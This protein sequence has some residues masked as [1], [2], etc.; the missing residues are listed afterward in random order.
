MPMN[1]GDYE[2]L[3]AAVAESAADDTARRILAFDIANALVGTSE[4]FDPVL[5]LR[6]C[7]IG[8]IDPQEVAQWSTLLSHRVQ[9]VS[10]RRLDYERRTGY[11]LERY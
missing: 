10:R 4:R 2:A 1:R 6:Q 9:S 7:N 8:S 5:W 11:R 3:S